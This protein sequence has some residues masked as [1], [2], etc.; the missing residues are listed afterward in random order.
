MVETLK[1]FRSYFTRYVLF[2]QTMTKVSNWK[3][4]CKNKFLCSF[5]HF[6]SN[7]TKQ[8]SDV[9]QAYWKWNCTFYSKNRDKPIL[10]SFQI[11]MTSMT[12]CLNHSSNISLY[13]CR[14]FEIRLNSS[15][16]DKMA[17]AILNYDK[18]KP[19]DELR[20][21][22]KIFNNIIVHIAFQQNVWY[23][24]I[25]KL[26]SLC[27]YATDWHT[28]LLLILL[29]SLEHLCS[30]GKQNTNYEFESPNNPPFLFSS[31]YLYSALSSKFLESN[32]T[33]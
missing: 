23:S 20:R 7:G 17:M 19:K 31:Y 11:W 1:S 25:V 3:K 24:V 28:Y 26:Q 30:V 6:E 16:K 2:C 18:T 29:A 33:T 4:K 5:N 15:R 32:G 14:H 21:S 8:L 12:L 22:A 9:T 27:R 10:F 13:Y